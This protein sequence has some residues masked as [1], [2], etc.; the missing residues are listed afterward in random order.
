MQYFKR[1]FRLGR[2]I[3]FVSTLIFF[4]LFLAFSASGQT[5]TDSLKVDSTKSKVESFA[6]ATIVSQNV[7]R[8]TMLDNKL[9]IQPLVG[10]GIGN[11]EIGAFGTVSLVNSYSEADLY[12][13]YSFKN[14]K[15]MFTDFYADLSGVANS[16]NY[17][18]YSD[19]S[20]YH[21]IMCDLI[22]L[23]T[24]KIPLRITASTMLYGGLDLYGSGKRRYT[25]YFEARY[26]YREWEMF[27]GAFSG[28]SDFY[29][30]DADGVNIGNVG[31]AYNYEIEISDKFKLPTIAQVCVNPQMKKFYFT[32]GVTF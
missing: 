7:W 9:N 23:G 19:T 30:N 29:M 17:F 8:G 32:F 22:F 14:M 20:G 28:G 11:F 3:I 26:L 12:A 21:H 6:G 24:E 13:S 25:T 31:V 1:R 27:V 4:F 18:D 5:T 10:L 16:Q 2:F 15:I